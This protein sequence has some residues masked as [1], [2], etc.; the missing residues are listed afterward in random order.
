IGT[1]S[2]IHVLQL[3][4]ATAAKQLERK[5]HP[6]IQSAA[7]RGLP[8]GMSG[9]R[10]PRAT[11]L[12]RCRYSATTM[13]VFGGLNRMRNGA[14][15]ICRKLPTKGSEPSTP[16]AADERGKPLVTRA[17]SAML[18]ERLIVTSGMAT[19]PSLVQLRRQTF[20]SALRRSAAARPGELPGSALSAGMGVLGV[21]SGVAPGGCPPGRAPMKTPP[22]PGDNPSLRA[23]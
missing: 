18:P 9:S 3:T 23:L 12:A 4:P 5:Y 1:H 11:Q 20:R 13:T 14:A 7:S 16:I 21:T 19:T 17:E 6:R 2:S 15:K 8:R 22:R 10:N